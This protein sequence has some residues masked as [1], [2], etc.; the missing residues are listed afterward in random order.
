MPPPR[1]PPIGR[2]LV[3]QRTKN[4]TV[5]NRGSALPPKIKCYVCKRDKTIDQYANVQLKRYQDTIYNPYAPAGRCTKDPK[6]TCKACTPGQT[7]ELFCHI[8]L[9]TMKLDKF[10][11]NQRDKPDKARCIKCVERHLD[12]EP[13]FSPPDS[14][15]DSDGSVGF[16][17]MR[18]SGISHNGNNQFDSN[19]ITDGK[20]SKALAK[21]DIIDDS[22]EDWGADDV[23]ANA[24][25]KQRDV[26]N[27]N[28]FEDD[29]TLE[30]ITN[31]STTTR[32]HRDPTGPKNFKMP[33][34]INKPPRREGDPQPRYYRNS[35]KKK[36]GAVEVEAPA[37]NNEWANY[38]RKIAERYTA[39][40]K[41][42]QDSD[43]DERDEW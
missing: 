34:P 15:Y 12:T 27:Y 43:D 35:G 6:T 18:I 5:T 9:Q 3:N 23:S 24:I 28:R 36:W 19:A 29:A 32:S 33:D 10:S 13:D 8:C 39:N 41:G 42:Q 4:N 7:Q 2:N 31:P 37:V 38:G 17:G 20:S 14:D 26:H 21:Q 25:D 16:D 1:Q 22:D 40:G 11:K 30:T